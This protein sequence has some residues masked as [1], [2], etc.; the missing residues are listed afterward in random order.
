MW[1]KIKMIIRLFFYLILMSFFCIFILNN[2]TV[3]DLNLYPFNYVI[4][5]KLFLLI[6][7]S[8][9][10]GFVFSFFTDIINFCYKCKTIIKNKFKKKA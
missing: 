2:S 1:L 3:V 6:L 7:I 4:E 8:F 9:F 10:F 5:I